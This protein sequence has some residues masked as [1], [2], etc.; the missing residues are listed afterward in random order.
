MDPILAETIAPF[1]AIFGVGTMVLIGMKLRYS[2]QARIAGRSG[3][4]EDAERLNGTV[5]DLIDEVHLLREGL[6]DLNE[7]M[8]FTERMLTQGKANELGKVDT[9]SH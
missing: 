6:A 8:E 2:H 9:P 3:S 7:R 4:S 1:L 5:G